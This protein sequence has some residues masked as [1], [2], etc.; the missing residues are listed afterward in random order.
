MKNIDQ[1]L[2]SKI[3]VSFNAN[4]VV[5]FTDTADPVELAILEDSVLCPEVMCFEWAALHHNISP[6]LNDLVVGTQ[7]ARGN[8]TDENKLL[9]CELEDGVV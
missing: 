9:L 3:K 6:I 2:K 7:C 1:M 8:R 4:Y 5:L